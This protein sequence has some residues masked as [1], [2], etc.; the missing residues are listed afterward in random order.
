MR[1][2]AEKKGGG[3]GQ[4]KFNTQIGQIFAIHKHTVNINET[5]SNKNFIP[6]NVDPLEKN[7]LSSKE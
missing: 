4:E 3:N 6:F 2:D 1:L 5:K 7:H